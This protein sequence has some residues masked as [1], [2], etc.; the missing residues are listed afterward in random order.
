M[1]LG[2]RGQRDEEKGTKRKPAGRNKRKKKRDARLTYAFNDRLET[3][4]PR[5][6]L[7]IRGESLLAVKRV[8]LYCPEDFH[9]G[10]RTIWTVGRLA[11]GEFPVY[12]RVVRA[13]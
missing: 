3:S 6:D 10:R 2:A 9:A 11:T 13:A 4:G 1:I 8:Q 12:K 5:V 7:S